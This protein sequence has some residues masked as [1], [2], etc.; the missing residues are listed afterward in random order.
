[1]KKLNQKNG[2]CS[3]HVRAPAWKQFVMVSS[4]LPLN[5]L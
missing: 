4:T 5:S 3:Y 1:M 2:L